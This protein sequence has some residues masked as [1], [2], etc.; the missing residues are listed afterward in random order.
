MIAI[1]TDFK[2]PKQSDRRQWLKVELLLRLG[3]DFHPGQS[4]PGPRP[5]RL[6]E[7]VDFVRTEHPR[8]DTARETPALLREIA[9][10]RPR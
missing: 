3:Y 8:S 5:R 4:G 7:A 1:G 2:A 10:K 9:R 6:S